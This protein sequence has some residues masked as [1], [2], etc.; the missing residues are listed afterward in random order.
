M[1]LLQTIHVALRYVALLN[2]NNAEA[3]FSCTTCNEKCRVSLTEKHVYIC[4]RR[5][6]NE[7][8]VILDIIMSD[9]ET[10]D[11]SCASNCEMEIHK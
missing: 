1:K 5:E 10:D 6:N 9:D 11:K 8:R 3:K 4:L 7:S 2:K